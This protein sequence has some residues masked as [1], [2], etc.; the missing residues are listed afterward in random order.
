VA[1]LIWSESAREDLRSI[2]RYVAR[3]SRQ[4]AARLAA[5]ITA[6]VRRLRM[7]PAGGRI[8]PEFDNP[9]YREVIVGNYRVIY[10]YDAE[11]AFVEVLMVVHGSRLLPPV[12]GSE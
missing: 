7:Y 12:P 10:R 4:A 5:N 11:R 1:R 3:D 8:V 2:Q 9:H 6:S